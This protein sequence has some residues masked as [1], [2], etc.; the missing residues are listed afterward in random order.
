MKIIW[1]TI[2][3]IYPPNTGGRIGIFRRLEQIA[4]NNDIYLFYTMDRENDRIYFDDL[5]KYC[6]EVHGFIREK[7]TLSTVKNLLRAPFTVASRK[8][9]KLID[10]VNKCLSENNIDLINVDSPHMG[11][12]LQEINIYKTPVVINQH[13]I[14]WMVY[15]NVS[16]ATH[17]I[18]KKILY[19]MESTRFK[20]Y[21]EKLYREVHVSLFTFVSKDDLDFFGEW[22]GNRDKLVLIP[23]GANSCPVD[24]DWNSKTN[25]IIFVG[26]MSYA[27]NEEAVK[28]FANTIFPTVKEKISDCR[29]IVVGKDPGAEIKKMEE[30][31]DGVIVTGEV[32][33]VGKYYN[34]ADLV[35]IPLLHGGGVKVKLL[36]A[37]GYGVPIISSEI[38]I[39]G[40]GFNDE[41]MIIATNATEFVKK[42]LDFLQHRQNYRNVYDN[43]RYTF[44]DAYTWESI[45]KSYNTALSRVIEKRNA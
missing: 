7:R 23:V 43:M 31:M 32:D 20:K 26:K 38:G 25:N 14:E 15:K 5:R 18:M 4:K 22:I 16:K 1:I 2:E 8:N 44:E 45:G 6:K 40:T 37:M 21:E 24:Y 42:V 13:N 39:Q 11:M 19:A 17:S 3:S 29:F 9:K 12:N 35:V 28:Y 34:E 27:P 30:K 36:E 33:D 41:N 10:A